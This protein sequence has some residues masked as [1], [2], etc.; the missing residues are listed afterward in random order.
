LSQDKPKVFISYS[1]EDEDWKDLIRKYFDAS[2]L[3]DMWDDRD[4]ELG[5]D[6][7]NEIDKAAIEAD[8]AVLLISV[9]FLNSS[10]IKNKE[11]PMLLNKD[12]NIK[13]IPILLSAAPWKHHNWLAKLQGYPKNFT[14]LDSFKV[15]NNILFKKCP[16]ITKEINNFVAKIYKEYSSSFLN[17]ESQKEL[18][19]SVLEL[20]K[21]LNQ[22]K[23]KVFISY[24]WDDN[25]SDDIKKLA[26][27]FRKYGV[28]CFLDRYTPKNIWNTWMQNGIHEADYI[29]IVCGKTY[30]EKFDINS[31]FK[32]SGVFQEAEYI[33][34]RLNLTG[35]DISSIFI[36]SF[37]NINKEHIPKELSRCDKTD[38]YVDMQLNQLYQHITNQVE[39]KPKLGSLVKNIPSDI[40]NNKKR[41]N[42]IEP[43]IA[44]DNNNKKNQ[45]E[46][47]ETIRLENGIELVE[48]KLEN[49][50]IYIGK[51]PVTFEEYDFFCDKK[52]KTKPY[53]R[54]WGRGKRPVIYVSL[55]DVEKYCK[56]LGQ[57]SS[58]M[59]FQLLSSTDWLK[60][61][62]LNSLNKYTEEAIWYNK[63]ETIEVDKTKIGSLG[64]Y[65]MYG[66]VEEW[67]SN[68]VSI[69]GSYR[70]KSSSRFD[71]MIERNK[72]DKFDFLGFRVIAIKK[73]EDN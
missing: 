30:K 40:F 36:L 25:N 47:I 10:F 15:D 3:F 21:D 54:S 26:D 13:I 31:K 27:N 12:S 53:D 51:Y 34:D 18:S 72:T 5:K 1:H 28:D 8:I 73:K 4:I 41:H 58:I 56:W 66:N 57:D 14:P 52:S 24:S 11:V 71:E 37:G 6:W 38:C 49:K 59:K 50:I 42:N 19:N 17:E 62:E 44:L 7:E 39:A 22:K 63:N 2:E 46:I 67:C 29:F 55:K 45:N 20:E 65:D 69:G 16:N 23:P 32:D 61:A 68:K 60:I 9:D 70:N 43:E 64:I 48:V 33:R 35:N